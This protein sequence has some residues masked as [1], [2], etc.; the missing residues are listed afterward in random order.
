VNSVIKYEFVGINSLRFD[1]KNLEINL[2]VDLNIKSWFNIE[3]KL[4]ENIKAEFKRVENLEFLREWD[5]LFISLLTV[6]IN[7]REIESCILIILMIYLT[8]SRKKWFKSTFSKLKNWELLNLTFLILIT[9]FW[10][11]I[12]IL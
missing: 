9:F 8:F 10:L 7:N 2:E 4:V 5:D 3:F 12:Y 11:D 1:I 6:I